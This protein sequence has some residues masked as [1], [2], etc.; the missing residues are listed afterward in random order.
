M[1][2]SLAVVGL[3]PRGLY[4]LECFAAQLNLQESTDQ[5][6]LTLFNDSEY[7]GAGPNYAPDQS[8]LNLLNIPGREVPLPR[9][10]STSGRVSI[11]E[12]PGYLEWQDEFSVVDRLG[13]DVFPTR[14]S[15]GRYLHARFNSWLEAWQSSH[16][17]TL[18][19]RA[20][21]SL[22]TSDDYV[23]L[24]D[25]A[26]KR[27]AELTDV[28]FTIGHQPETDDDSMVSWERFAK[29]STDCHLVKHPYPTKQFTKPEIFTNRAVAVR[30]LGLSMIDTVKAL[31][32]GRGGSFKEKAGE[33]LAFEYTPSGREPSQI[34]PFSLD[35]LPM[36]PKPANEAIDLQFAL[37][38]SE[39]T[40]LVDVL[41]SHQELHDG[42]HLR[43]LIIDTMA[44]LCANVYIRLGAK[45]LTMDESQEE[46]VR[47]V[48]KWFQDE[49]F[50][51]VGIVS[52]KICT[53]AALKV[54]MAMATG[55]ALV[56]IDYCA[57]QVWRQC[58]KMFYRELA[59]AREERT[60]LAPFIKLDQR[61]KRYAFGPPVDSVARQLALENAGLV[62]FSVAE[63]PVIRPD[64]N[65]WILIGRDDKVV[66]DVMI[67]TVQ[68]S[69]ALKRTTSDIVASL[70]HDNLLESIND[71]LGAKTQRDGRIPIDHRAQSKVSIAFVGRLAIGNVIEA[72]A[73]MECFGPALESWATSLV[74]N[75][76]PAH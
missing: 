65:H 4:A 70:V 1:G 68:A 2:R 38:S 76:R 61:M 59:F 29:G 64:D 43:E 25:G 62:R 60:F 57:G 12:F 66:A 45:C 56:S 22:D 37:E 71:V 54:F 46:V 5:W 21:M 69:P 30:G 52:H 9:R 55:H 19:E 20:V 34:L 27:Y 53:H 28:I 6:L 48:K 7:P 58:Q 39:Q 33:R 26:G 3:G 32:E 44:E 16:E 51:H 14:A 75:K 15:I 31:T 24:V 49:S 17:F 63:D 73:L 18:V 42:Q 36:A 23:V 41:S 50:Q 10:P 47:I 8:A 67:D 72:D 40:L 11:P 35:G 13:Y 74:S